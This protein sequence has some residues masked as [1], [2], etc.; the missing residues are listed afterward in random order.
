M[1]AESPRPESP[2]VLLVG[3]GTRDS[4]GTEQFFRLGEKLQTQLGSIPVASSLLEFQE[5]TIAQGWDSLVAQ[6]AKHIHVAPLLL[7]AAGHAKQDIPNEIEACVSKTPWVSHDQS[8]PI[9]RHRCVIDLVVHRLGETLQQTETPMSRTAIVM[10]GR[11]NRDPCAQAD[12]RILSEVVARRLDVRSV[13]TAFYAMAEPRLP[14][15]LD[16]VAGS[17][18]FDQV[19]V[20]PHLL[21]EGR[22]NQAILGQVREADERHSAVRVQASNY[23]GPE[24]AI[25]KAIADRI[26]G[27][28]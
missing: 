13:V 22:L 14:A 1:N 16:Q 15:V 19:I 3:H 20:H 21:F 24:E 12:M 25:A 5:P 18:R 23:L 8:R 27:P 2:A 9:S 17:D 4:V 10:V 7:F 26:D 28:H 11:G 6:G